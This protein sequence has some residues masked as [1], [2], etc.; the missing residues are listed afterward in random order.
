VLH[1]Y[2][3]KFFLVLENNQSL[4]DVSLQLDGLIWALDTTT[5]NS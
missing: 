1:Q 5:M 4:I 2:I 3:S